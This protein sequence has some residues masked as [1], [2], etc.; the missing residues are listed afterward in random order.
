MM[1]IYIYMGD[2]FFECVFTIISEINLLNVYLHLCGRYINHFEYLSTPIWVIILTWYY[3]YQV[4]Y[5]DIYFLSKKQNMM[6]II[7]KS[8]TIL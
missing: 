1:C 8:N 6:F 3:Y 7:L 5:K 2:A 4:G